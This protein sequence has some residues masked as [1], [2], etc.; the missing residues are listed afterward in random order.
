MLI[1]PGMNRRMRM[2]SL[3]IAGMKTFYSVFANDSMGFGIVWQSPTV[4][5]GI[6]I[7]WGID[8]QG[9]L[10]PRASLFGRSRAALIVFV[11]LVP[12]VSLQVNDRIGSC[13]RPC[14]SRL[15]PGSNRE[16]IDDL[17]EIVLLYY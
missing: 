16:C 12:K 8:P 2:V 6:V 15:N 5:V 13:H 9:L 3:F 10:L 17:Y 1:F 14:N 11:S 7:D 4:E